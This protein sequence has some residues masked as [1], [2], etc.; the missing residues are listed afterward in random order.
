[1][2]APSFAR[3]GPTPDQ[4]R[5]PAIRLAIE[6]EF[7]YVD[8]RKNTGS[9]L[10]L[11]AGEAGTW[12]IRVTNADRDLAE[13]TAFH[14]FS[15]N[16]HFAHKLQQEEPR[17]R[18]YTTL[19]RTGT[20][21]LEMETIGRGMGPLGTVVVRAGT[22]RTGDSFT[23]VIG[24]R[25][26]GSVGSEVFWTAGEGALV[27]SCDP[28]GQGTYYEAIDSPC[29]L[30]V[31]AHDKLRLVR[32]LAP[33]VVRTAQPFSVHIG[34]FDRGGNVLEAY[35]G[36]LALDADAELCGLPEIVL[37]RAEGGGQRIVENVS[38]GKPGVFRIRGRSS[39]G[40]TF[41]SNP[42]VVEDNPDTFIYWGDLHC[43]G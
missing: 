16:Y 28:N 43:H 17:K 14:F 9:P 15:M 29:M 30:E 33:T 25:S 38:V 3:T 39:D 22:F 27:V 31:C 32:L 37:F 8:G 42:I 19:R 24:D 26:G 10:R 34:L 5:R 21:K 41:W 12:R 18:D 4:L 13:G 35:D 23:I 2:P 40:Q 6:L 7:E 20:A 1:M 36:E 11:I